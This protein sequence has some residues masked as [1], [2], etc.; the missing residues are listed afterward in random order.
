MHFQWFWKYATQK[1]DRE[2]TFPH[3]RTTTTDKIGLGR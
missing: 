3:Y 1:D 2:P